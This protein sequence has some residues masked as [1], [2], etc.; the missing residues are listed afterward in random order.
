MEI[1]QRLKVQKAVFLLDSD[2][3]GKDAAKKVA[4]RWWQGDV[5]CFIAELPEGLD[6]DEIIAESGPVLL[7]MIIGNAK[8]ALE[9]RLW[10][11]WQD[12]PRSMVAKMDFLDWITATYGSLLNAAEEV[13][14]AQHVSKWL[15]LPEAQVLDFN[16]INKSQLNDPDSEAIVISKCVRNMNY[17]QDVRKRLVT[18]DFFTIRHQRIWQALEELLIEG[19]DFDILV[20]KQR[21]MGLGVDEEYFTQMLDSGE[22]NMRYHEDRVADLALRRE[23][24]EKADSFRERISDLEIDA[25]ESIG[26]L[27]LDVTRKTLNGQQG[28]MTITDQVDKAMEVFHERMRNPNAVHGID[29]GTQFPVLNQRMQGIQKKR[30]VLVAA[31]SGVGKTT[32]TVQ[33]AVNMAVNQ[34]IPVD[35][36]SLEMDDDE[37]LFKATAHLTGI[38]GEKITSGAVTPEEAKVIEKAMM[39]I[40]KSPLRIH[41]PD[42]ITPSEFVLYARESVMARRTEAFFLDY[43]QMAS[44]DPGMERK[45]TYEQLKEFGRIAKTQIARA[46]N[47][48]VICPAQ[49]SRASGEKDRP[50]KEDMGDSYDLSRTADV[51][52][53]LKGNEDSDMVDMWLDKNRQGSG[54]HLIPTMFKKDEQ[55]FFEQGGMH[56]PDYR[57]GI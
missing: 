13:I 6:P 33:W 54:G 8:W 40:K 3:A 9:Y 41:A 28:F 11:E 26:T 36:I 29:L 21:A 12:K 38:D 56:E 52:I 30:L 49:L 35:Y 4:E 32:I 23:A 47:V 14:V 7:E 27:T 55:S 2:R 46:M 50:T 5:R 57:V 48:A 31:T 43:I 1:L 22:S 17:Y 51:V 15:E 16:R 20:V 39:R 37:L 10:I 24:K 42:T 19:L 45:Q 25:S 18:T 44:P 53:I 34:S